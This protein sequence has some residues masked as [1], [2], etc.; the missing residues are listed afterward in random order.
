MFLRTGCELPVA[1]SLLQ[2]N[3]CD[4]WMS[5]DG[6]TSSVLDLAVRKAGW[7]FIWLVAPHSSFGIGQTAESATSSAVVLALKNIEQRFNAAELCSVKV[8]KYPGFR[9]ARVTLHPRQIQPNVSLGL[10]DEITLRECS[11]P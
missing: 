7:H 3:F 11:A 8:T 9:V 2:R 1:V 6:M 4:S 5:A 10:A